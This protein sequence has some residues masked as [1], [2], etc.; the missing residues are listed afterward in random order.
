M[1]CMSMN[2]KD[3]EKVWVRSGWK[4]IVCRAPNT[5]NTLSE[6]AA[7]GRVIR[8]PHTLGQEFTVTS[9]AIQIH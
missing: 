3:G 4:R 9:Q 6:V 7:G 5:R 1:I 8:D 2:D